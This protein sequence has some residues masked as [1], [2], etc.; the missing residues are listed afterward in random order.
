MK[1]L[2]GRSLAIRVVAPIALLLAVLV[3]VGVMVLT[4]VNSA[5][6]SRAI[7]ERA[8]VTTQVIAG[9]LSAALWDVD[10]AAATQLSGLANDPDY[11]KSQ[12]LDAKGKP[13]VSHGD[14]RGQADALS[15]KADIVRIADGKT[16]VLGGLALPFEVRALVD[17]V[18]RLAFAMDAATAAAFQTWFER[19][20]RR[21]AA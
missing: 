8:S 5:D 21:R 4:M 12:V 15:R 9:G 2:F 6:A 14:A 18:P 16:E 17:G 3:V 19:P 7:E 11:L 20:R 1:Q 10:K 13:F